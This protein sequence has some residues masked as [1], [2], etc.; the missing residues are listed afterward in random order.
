MKVSRLPDGGITM[1]RHLRATKLDVNKIMPAAGSQLT[2]LKYPSGATLISSL[3]SISLSI[4]NS[5]SVFHHS[6]EHDAVAADGHQN[7]IDAIGMA[8]SANR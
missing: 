4:S 8:A 7:P 5:E 2:C 6:V 1:A 3:L